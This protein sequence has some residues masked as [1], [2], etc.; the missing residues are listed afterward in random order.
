MCMGRTSAVFR[1]T[2]QDKLKKYRK[3]HAKPACVTKAGCSHDYELSLLAMFA[4]YNAIEV[5]NIV[6]WEA[7][8]RNML[9]GLAVV[10]RQVVRGVELE[11]DMG[12]ADGGKEDN[13]HVD[14]GMEESRGRLLKPSSKRW[15]VY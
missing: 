15:T 13:G 9:M 2:L 4:I 11:K 7:G 10:A 14:S 12:E 8:L 3:D 6:G 5:G 1:K